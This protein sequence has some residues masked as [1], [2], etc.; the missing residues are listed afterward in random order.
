MELLLQLSAPAF[1]LH[2]QLSERIRRVLNNLQHSLP[3]RPLI[4]VISVIDAGGPA[5]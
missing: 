3:L 4:E 1:G 5:T 2:D